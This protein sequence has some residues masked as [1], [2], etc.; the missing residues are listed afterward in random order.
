[1]EEKVYPSNSNAY[2][3]QSQVPP[4][5]QTP[6]PQP[7][8]PT[9]QYKEKSPAKQVADF[10]GAGNLN[11]FKDYITFAADLTNRIYMAI[12]LI[13]GHRTTTPYT[14]A[15]VGRPAYSSMFQPAQTTGVQTNTAV[16]PRSQ[17]VQTYDYGN[18]EYPNRGEAERVLAQLKLHI[19]EFGNVSVNDWFD[20]SYLSS[21]NSYTDCKFGWTGIPDTVMPIE[22]RTM[23]GLKYILPLPAPVRIA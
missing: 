12:D 14:T 9:A 1:M 8:V 7:T 2:R 5:P 22:V 16:P 18:I 4:Q 10:F 19:S 23:N 15:T 21:P 13:T 11:T 20:F 3:A 17:V 6:P